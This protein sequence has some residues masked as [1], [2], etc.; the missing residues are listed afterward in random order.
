[1]PIRLTL[2]DPSRMVLGVATGKLTI[3]ELLGFLDEFRKVGKTGYRKIIDF[4]GAEADFDEAGL[5]PFLQRHRGVAL[6]GSLEDS[7]GGSLDGPRGPLALVIGDN[8]K[9]LARLFATLTG[10]DRPAEVFRTIHGAREWIAQ[11]SAQE[12]GAPRR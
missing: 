1:M 6:E 8:Q 4:S 10:G 5:A 7:P 11:H 12:K 3:E 9:G 2:H